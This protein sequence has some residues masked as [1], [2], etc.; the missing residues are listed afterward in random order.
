[1]PGT[2]PPGQSELLNAIISGHSDDAVLTDQEV[3]GGLRNFFLFVKPCNFTYFLNS[4]PVFCSLSS[5]GFSGECL[6]QHSGTHQAANLGDGNDYSM[7]LPSFSDACSSHV[8]CLLENE[9]AVIRWNYGDAQLGACQETIQGGNH[10][11]YWTQDGSGN[12]R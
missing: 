1:M 5:F 2:F 12:N 3:K 11:R 9:T 10:F 7:S 4:L 6:G 8:T